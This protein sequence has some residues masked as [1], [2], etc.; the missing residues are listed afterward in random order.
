MG[1]ADATASAAAA[2]W[3]ELAANGP[4]GLAVVDARGRFVRLNQTAA[5]LCRR[6][7]DDLAGT[8]APFGITGADTGDA[9]S[10][11]D[12]GPAEQVTV[13]TPRPGIRRE[14][15]YRAQPLPG[16]PSLTLVAFRDVTSERLR[17]RRV[18]AI[19]R[20]A[21]KL[22]SQGSVSLTAT[23]DALAAEVVQTDALAG[24][25]I[26]V[27]DA[28]GQRPQIMGMAGFRHHADFLDRLME[29]Q[30]RG[31]ALMTLD[32]FRR[33]EPVVVAGRWASVSEDPAWEPLREYMR[34]PAW[35]FFASIPLLVRG[36]PAGVLN[37]FFAPGQ[38]I[39]PRTL[40][41]LAAMAEQA[42]VA[43]DY[44]ALL[45]RERD[46]ARREERQRLARDLHDSIVQH[47]FSISMQ[48]KSMEVLGERGDAVPAEAVRRIA[49]EVGLLSRTA[50]ADLRAMV[51][52]LRPLSAAEFGGVAEAVREL[53]DST[54]NRTGLR[55]RLTV[56]GALERVTGELA[57]DI[58]RIVAEAIHNVVKHAD[59]GAVHI[60]LTERADRF[61]ATVADDGAGIGPAA[62]RHRGVPGAGAGYGLTTMRER[63][64][65]WGGTVTVRPRRAPGT[66]VRL[67]VPLAQGSP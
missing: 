37:A 42:A 57:E 39:G 64:Q 8:P 13:W 44:A 63:A 24:A 4:E 16:D 67:V 29:C 2:A 60:R 23:L 18:A 41:F 55:V 12:D 28:A 15:A 1:G 11:F 14:F 22:A 33:G 48:A 49:N 19:A 27:L 9:A 59:A 45:R 66:I 6:G 10:L 52:E 38:V 34:E 31:A 50:L 21:A 53:A 17:Q 65:R 56:S 32:A 51:H 40:E 54:A 62:A 58:Y 30:R 43:V 35:D 20:T 25:Q 36:K 7:V 5:E 3:A 26:M 47:V 46:S 61:T